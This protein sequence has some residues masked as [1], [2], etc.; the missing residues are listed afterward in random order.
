MPASTTTSVRLPDPLRRELERHARASKR[1]KNWIIKEAL[2]QYLHGP[3]Q[4]ELRQEACRQSEMA[5]RNSPRDAGWGEQGGDPDG[6][7]A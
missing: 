6:W 7:R 1:G 3:A 2:A 5:S 4:D